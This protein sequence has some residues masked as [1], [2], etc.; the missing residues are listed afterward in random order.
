MFKNCYCSLLDFV[1]LFHMDVF[2]FRGILVREKIDL[3][4]PFEMS[5]KKLN[6]S[7]SKNLIILSELHN[8]L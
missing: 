6:C 2:D 4:S 8:I 3:Y 1:I 5:L 7:Y